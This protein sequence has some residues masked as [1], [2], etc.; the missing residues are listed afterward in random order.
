MC[1]HEK[2]PNYMGRAVC[3]WVGRVAPFV[4]GQERTRIHMFIHYNCTRQFLVPLICHPYHEMIFILVAFTLTSGR[5]YMRY[6]H[7]RM[8]NK[9]LQ[10]I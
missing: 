2:S 6:T 5:S 8:C 1:V 10:D 9:K 7:A 4:S 3:A